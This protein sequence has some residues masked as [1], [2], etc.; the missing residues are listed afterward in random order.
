MTIQ[1]FK[2]N[3]TVLFFGFP[4]LL[5]IA[6]AFYVYLPGTHGLFVLDD[7]ENLSAIGKYK[8]FSLW[9]NFW[10]FIL[11][12]HSGPTGRPISLASFY[13]NTSQWPAEP[14]G[15]IYTNIIIH[16][17]NGI[18]VFWISFK[19][20]KLFHLSTNQQAFFALFSS[21]LWLLN[22]MHTTTVLYIVQRMTELSA[23]FTLIGVLFYL[24]GR[25]K[26]SN[27][28]KIAFLLLFLG[29]G[30]SLI[31]SILSKEN[32]IL[33]VAY[34]LAIE[35]F[36]LQPLKYYPPEKFYYWLIPAV[37]IPFIFI[38]AYL[39]M[40]TTN[41]GGFAERNFTLVERLLTEPRIIFDYLQHILLPKSGSNSLFHDDYIV[42]KN[43]LSPWTTLPA[44]I[45]VITLILLSFIVRKK[46]PLIA[47]AIAWFFSGH[48]IESTVLP[49]ELY[50]EHRNYLPMLGLFIAIAYYASKL[51]KTN[52]V[53]TLS[54]S[55][56]FIALFSFIVF[57]STTLWAK[58]VEQAKAWYEKHPQS[59]R[60]RELYRPIAQAQ[61]IR[62]EPLDIDKEKTSLFYATS[63]LLKLGQSCTTKQ[64]TQE[65]L[66][67][68]SMIIKEHVLHTSASSALSNFVKTWLQGKCKQL[69]F[70]DIES[71]LLKLS[72][73]KN[74]QKS[75]D[76]M[77]YLHYYLSEAYRQ[78]NDL[79]NTITHL[80]K[81]YSYGPNYDLLKVRAT[82][83]SS[84][85]LFSEALKVLDDTNK[86]KH[87][88]RQKLALKIKQKELDLM[89]EAIN[90]NMLTYK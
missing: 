50:F 39:G 84:A 87:G 82:T 37:V 60:T 43:L 86:L 7:F 10:L 30:L 8:N 2:K 27:N 51:L 14:T 28:K 58:P 45:G 74:A 64:I 65:D 1:S 57:Q 35:F 72:T 19:L 76:F 40:H 36:L 70:N 59:L 73:Y 63:T 52:K 47:F 23:M 18:L 34:I 22:P 71:F 77:R 31:F 61:G 81:A 53:A 46:Q 20:S 62:L 6:L 80:N 49:L 44:I 66:L 16:L 78:R 12:G 17:I 88:F 29:M 13:L 5:L 11:E 69:S 4:L 75:N 55:S 54:L 48:I 21:A 32:G 3:Q 56:I 38:L 85:G 25:D 24:Y 41:T 79:N 89:K 42:S 33:L 9:D 15:F 26:L 83:L 67:S 90:K 68:T